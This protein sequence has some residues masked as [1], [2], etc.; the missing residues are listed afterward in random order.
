MSVVCHYYHYSK[1]DILWT[2]GKPHKNYLFTTKVKKPIQEENKYHEVKKC[3]IAISGLLHDIGKMTDYFQYKIRQKE[4]LSDPLRHEWLSVALLSQN[5]DT[6]NSL[7]D[8]MI[9][10]SVVISQIKDNISITTKDPVLKVINYLI[11]THHKKPDV[12]A[13]GELMK[14][15]SSFDM[16]YDN[17][18]CEMG[19]INT[20]KLNELNKCNFSNKIDLGREWCKMAS[21]WSTR[22]KKCKHLLEDLSEEHLISLVTECR[23]ALM[24]GDAKYSSLVTNTASEHSVIANK[25]DSEYNQTLQDHLVGVTKTALRAF[26]II[27]KKYKKPSSHIQFFDNK[28]T[29]KYKWQNQINKIPE[30]L[31]G[32]FMI[33]I[34]S[35]GYGKTISNLKMLNRFGN[36]SC[37]NALGMKSLVKQTFEDIK[38][39]AKVDSNDLAYVTGDTENMFIQEEFNKS[40]S[41]VIP[42]NNIHS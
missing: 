27:H 24:L 4:V 7:I 22:F 26:D 35:T 21:K 13:S 30:D 41:S 28:T 16:L 40:L 23:T 1:L 32:A 3:L 8:D 17:I 5:Y 37:I 6:V 36:L 10:G 29:G 14:S 42:D 9:R 18:Q 11:L 20:E 25:R 2:V 34:T 33:N 12:L 15:I 19:W 31:D 38:A 39:L